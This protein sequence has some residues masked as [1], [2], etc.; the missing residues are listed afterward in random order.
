[1]EYWL[2]MGGPNGISLIAW[3]IL[4]P[5]S[6]L[7]TIEVVPEGRLEGYTPALGYLAGFLSH[8]VTGLVL[9]LGKITILKN[10]HI[11]PRPILTLAVFALAGAIRGISV[12]YM[13][14]VFEI[15]QSSD[16]LERMRSGAVLV[17]V[18]FAVSAVLVDGWKNY[19]K[20]FLELSEKLESQKALRDAGAREL[21]HKLDELLTQIR[22][23]L[24]DAL[25]YGSSSS[26]IHNAVD[27][28]VRPLSHKIETQVSNFVSK[29]KSPRRRLKIR[30]V[31]RT[32]LYQTPFNPAWTALMAIVGTFSSRIWQFGLPAI[33]ESVVMAVTIWA[34][35]RVARKLKLFGFLAPIVWLATGLLTSAFSSLFISGSISLTPQLLYLSVNVFVPAAI[36][37][38]I[39]AFDRNAKQNLDLVRSVIVDLEWQTASLQQRSWVEQRRIA[40]FVHSELQSRL[41]AFALRMDLAARMP[42]D[43]EIEQLKLEC[44][45][46]LSI[47]G[48]Q[49]DFETFMR[50][51]TE[52]WQGAMEV[53]FEPQAQALE[54]LRHD[55]YASAAAIELVREGLSNAAKHGKASLATVRLELPK[56]STSGLH[57]KVTNNGL[58]LG[59]VSPGFG[60]GV[61]KELALEWQLESADGNTVLDCLIPIQ[62]ANASAS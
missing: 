29:T 32:A 16:Y 30:P 52:L 25:R 62:P 35:F 6:I 5:I 41:R 46:S 24:A 28:L 8:L 34:S 22:L 43:Q 49:Q 12:G 59:P 51:V 23:T 3:L 20:T 37:S 4:A 9:W 27:S 60:L 39:G 57:I 2:R 14:E 38:F 54:A 21:Q 7:F 17:L 42:T 31:I 15:T 53:I 18:W 48:K 55:G 26:D 56:S 13:F 10:A 58:A 11:R 36:V 19:K 50:D 40:R 61:I 44:E 45:Q 33:L 1:M 47:G